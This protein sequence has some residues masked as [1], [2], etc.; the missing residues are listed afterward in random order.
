[1]N[2]MKFLNSIISE[3]TLTQFTTGGSKEAEI[4][5]PIRGPALP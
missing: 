2:K 1:M 4:A 5:M 3:R